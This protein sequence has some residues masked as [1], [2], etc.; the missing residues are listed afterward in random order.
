MVEETYLDF[1]EPLKS[2]EKTDCIILHHSGVSTPHTVND[3]HKWH[4]KKGWA[5]IGYHY[6][7]S[8]DGIIYRGRPHHT[9]GAHARGYNQNSVG[10]CFEGDFNREQMTMEQ[11]AGEVPCFLASLQAYYGCRTLFCDELEGQKGHEIKGFCKEKFISFLEIYLDID[12]DNR[13]PE[14]NWYEYLE[15]HI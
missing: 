10:V 8:K 2:R 5:G 3:V 15:Q 6:F 7:I 14:D 11:M 13:I 4:Q 1:N 9:V 12:P